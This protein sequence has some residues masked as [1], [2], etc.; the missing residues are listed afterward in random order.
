MTRVCYSR[1]HHKNILTSYR[2]IGLS[3]IHTYDMISTANE[4]QR[5]QKD[6]D[7]SPKYGKETALYYEGSVYI[8]HS[9]NIQM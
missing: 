6:D 3:I 2:L 9:Y 1:I 5:K 7:K 4:T 8:V